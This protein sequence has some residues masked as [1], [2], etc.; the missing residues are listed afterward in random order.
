MAAL[1]IKDVYDIESKI[2]SKISTLIRE[3]VD[4]CYNEYLDK[5]WDTPTSQGEC[6]IK[7]ITETEITKRT[8]KIIDEIFA[9]DYNEKVLKE[10]M[11][12]FLPD[13]FVAILTTKLQSALSTADTN[14]HS[15]LFANI[16]SEIEY[17]INKRIH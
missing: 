11:I 7:S 15:T 13:I 9:T 4:N 5:Y 10:L 1:D 17:A 12:R 2:S 3:E 14:Y 6:L 16:R 8:Q